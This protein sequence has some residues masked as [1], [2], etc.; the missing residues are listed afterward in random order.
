M[1]ISKEKI[2]QIIAE[3]YQS[4]VLE[5]DPGLDPTTASKTI[6]GS[7]YKSK[8]IE[9][10]KAMG[11]SKNITPI[12]LTTIDAVIDLLNKYAETTDNK[13]RSGIVGSA[14]KSLA[15]AINKE[16][17]KAGSA[18]APANVAPPKAE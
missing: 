15:I 18:A 6:S 9:K 1:K 11:S 5:Q 4:I 2:K 12:E 14:I 8:G 13:I 7:A 3:E 16:L 17:K 10:A